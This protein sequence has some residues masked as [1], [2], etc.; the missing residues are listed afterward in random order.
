MPSFLFTDTG[1]FF[2]PNVGTLSPATGA[3]VRLG[4]GNHAI[5]GA[6]TLAALTLMMPVNPY[7]GSRVT[8]L[9]GVAVTALTLQT[10]TGG[11]I[12]GAPTAGVAG[13]PITMLWTGTAWVTEVD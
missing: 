7:V 1:S 12:T 11:A 4:R 8:I 10:A 6:A 5:A 2:P 13:K 9:P 3:T